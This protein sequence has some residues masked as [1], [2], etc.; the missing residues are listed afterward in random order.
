[1]RYFFIYSAGGG[2]GDWNGLKR[3]WV[4]DMPI[5][6]KENILLKFGDVFFNHASLN[7]LIKP[8]L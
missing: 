7:N 8:R 2:A 1:M 4:S 6:L 5:V 3:I